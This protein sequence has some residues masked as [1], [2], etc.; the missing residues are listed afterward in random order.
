MRIADPRRFHFDDVGAEIGKHCR[1]AGT[2]QETAEID[3][4]LSPKKCDPYSCDSLASLKLAARFSRNA[5]VPSFLSS[6]EVQ[7]A[8]MDDSRRRPSE[9]ARFKA[10]IHCLQSLFHRK[11]SVASHQFQ[12]RFGPADQ[13]RRG[14][15]F[16]DQSNAISFLRALDHFCQ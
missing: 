6:V 5:V 1:R 4:F 9:S 10:F 13:L 2:R 7:I 3:N 8:T 14:D 15:D 12:N 16:I 11:R